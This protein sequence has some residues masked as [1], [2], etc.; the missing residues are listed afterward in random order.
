MEFSKESIHC[1]STCLD[2]MDHANFE[3]A[4][5]EWIHAMHEDLSDMVMS[6]SD[7]VDPYALSWFMVSILEQ[8]RMTN[9]KPTETELLCKIEDKIQSLC[10]PR[11][12]F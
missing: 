1:T 7:H 3:I 12:P 10:T 6:R 11:L 8:A 9:H 5:L 2:I 4:S